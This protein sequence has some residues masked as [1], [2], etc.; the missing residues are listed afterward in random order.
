MLTV[1]HLN[2]SQSERVVWLCEELAIPYELVVHPRDPVTRM[3]PPAYKALHP[4]GTAPVIVDDGRVLAESG[5]IVEYIIARHGGGRLAV[6]PDRPNYA[7]YLYWLHF[8]NGS[9]MPNE[10]MRLVG[11]MLDPKGENPVMQILM[12]RSDTAWNMIERRL[13]EAPYFAGDE[14]TAADVMNGFP[15]T[16]MRMIA[17]RDLA[18]LPHV[19]AYLQRIG[20]R[21]AYRRAMEKG[22]PGMPLMLD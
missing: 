13:S 17:P 16:T 10:L 14:F 3:A 21:P 18:T 9:L 5:A 8:S 1:H 4:Q 19:R 11:G 12:A 15:L 2:M 6:T 7:D 22:D 20:A